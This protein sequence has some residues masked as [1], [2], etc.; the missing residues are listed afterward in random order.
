[1]T[2][3]QP[4]RDEHQE[5]RPHIDVLTTAADSVG[6]ASIEHVRHEVGA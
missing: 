5:L 6:E 3:T 4:L 1:M 2:V